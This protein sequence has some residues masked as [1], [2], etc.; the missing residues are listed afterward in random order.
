MSKDTS[1]AAE[2][3]PIEL[4]TDAKPP[5]TAGNARK[6]AIAKDWR[7]AAYLSLAG[8]LFFLGLVGAVLPGL[9]ATPFLLLT[10]YF[11][12]RSSPKL[13]RRLL[14]SRLFGPILVDWQVHGGVR[15]H[16][17]IKAVVVVLLTV[18]FTIY[19]SGY[20]MVSTAAISALAA[21][22]IIVIFRLPVARDEDSC[23]QQRD[24][25]EIERSPHDNSGL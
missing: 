4:Y 21:V 24:Q 16:V 18:V 11:L 12:I 13:N 2:P 22:G 17:K 25:P 19:L 7:K 1:P 5:I 23:Q 8:V 15:L 6:H 14:Q 10:S 9:P 3:E 20:S